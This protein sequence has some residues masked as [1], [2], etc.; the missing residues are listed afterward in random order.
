MEASIGRK[1]ERKSGPHC[2]QPCKP[3]YG[4]SLWG[5]DVGLGGTVAWV[6]GTVQS[7][8]HT[9]Q[10]GPVYCSRWAPQNCSQVGSTIF[11]P[12][13]SYAS[14]HP[15]LSFNVTN[16]SHTS[17]PIF[18]MNHFNITYTNIFSLTNKI[19]TLNT[20]NS[21]TFQTNILLYSPKRN[22]QHNKFYSNLSS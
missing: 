13:P 22:K 20:L 7:G 19:H 6:H 12:F 3:T 21:N 2:Q 15:F 17:L 10:S 4:Q 9:V 5:P 8:L 11:F 18:P 14:L 1:R 16:L